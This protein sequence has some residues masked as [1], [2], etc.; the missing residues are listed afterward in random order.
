VL[1]QMEEHVNNYK[2][3]K[4]KKN[5]IVLIFIMLII[6]CK[7]DKN[8]LKGEILLK[9]IDIANLYHFPD[10]ITNKI[11]K[12]LD[13][14]ESLKNKKIKINDS[15]N[16]YFFKLKK[17]NLLKSP[18]V[19][20]YTG[21]RDNDFKVVFLDSKEYE[22]IKKFDYNYLIQN[23]KKVNLELK[24]KKIEGYILYSNKII[25]FHEEN[26]YSRTYK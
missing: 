25:Y 3:K 22:K 19:Y 21:P 11:I 23:H 26:G 18:Y 9:G 20:V 16:D 12:K 6:S 24:I 17:Y 14:I 5:I 2:M 1:L 15:S 10:S 4:M 8:I 13:S 7:E